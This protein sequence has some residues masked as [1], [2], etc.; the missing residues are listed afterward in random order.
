MLG[1]ICHIIK[2]LNV[3][4]CEGLMLGE[5]IKGCRNYV[6]VEILFHGKGLPEI[7]EHVAGKVKGL[8]LNYLRHKIR[9]MVHS[10]SF[11]DYF[12]VLQRALLLAVHIPQS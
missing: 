8:A 5:G 1:V 9:S 6:V 2:V 3:P 4:G 11:L 12:W 7:G 10:A